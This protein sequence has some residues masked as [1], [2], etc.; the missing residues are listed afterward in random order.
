MYYAIIIIRVYYCVNNL[1]KVEKGNYFIFRRKKKKVD[2]IDSIIIDLLKKN[3]RIKVKEIAKIVNMSA[4]AISQRI[5]KLEESGIIDSFTIKINYN[6]L[7]MSVHQF[8]H[9]TMIQMSHKNYL[10]FIEKY[11]ENIINH[12]RIS[13]DTCYMLE[14]RFNTNEELTDFLRKLNIYANY[15]VNTVISVL[16]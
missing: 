4:P 14:T 6:A 2:N 5:I 9:A 7:G 11:S 13:G 1:R 12:Y 15:K 8:I 3:S 10:N 16:K